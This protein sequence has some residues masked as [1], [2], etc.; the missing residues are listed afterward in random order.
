VQWSRRFAGLRLF[1]TLATAGWDGLGRHV[2]RCLEL[3]SRLELLLRSKGWTIVNDP[4]MSVICSMP[5]AG[6]VDV[7]RIIAGLYAQGRHWCS[8]ALFEGQHVVRAC[9][10]NS[11]TTEADVD[12]LAEELSALANGA[13]PPGRR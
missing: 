5:A 11:V 2:E 8:R 3:A 1:L 13:E 10:T 4:G 7:D 12:A 9:I 6:S